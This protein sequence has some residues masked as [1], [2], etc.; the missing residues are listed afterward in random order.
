MAR[1]AL[2]GGAYQR[3]LL[4]AMDAVRRASKVTRQVWADWQRREQQSGGTLVK[5]DQSPVTGTQ[6]F[7]TRVRLLDT[8]ALSNGNYHGKF[9]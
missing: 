4:V 1:P 9:I 6:R 3:E 7:E 5:A 8:R 2:A